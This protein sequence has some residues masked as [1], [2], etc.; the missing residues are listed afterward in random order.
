MRTGER[1]RGKGRA[2]GGAAWSGSA[3]A[4]AQIPGACLVAGGGSK[5]GRGTAAAA[6]AKSR[7][8][9]RGGAGGGGQE[10]ARVGAAGCVFHGMAPG[11][12]RAR[13]VTWT[14]RCATPMP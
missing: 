1:G 11:A 9:E 6:A 10:R 8:R 14:Q 3:A 5:G 13:M 4:T 12:P 7:Y 2:L